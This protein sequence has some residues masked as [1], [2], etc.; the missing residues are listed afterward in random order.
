MADFSG[1]DRLWMGLLRA[2]LSWWARP[3]VLP[4][5]LQQRFAGHERPICYVLNVLGAADL[6]VL[7]RVCAA[8]GLP[9][10]LQALRRPLPQQSV[11]FLERRVGFWSDRIDH[12]ISAPMRQLVA[13]AAADRTLEV[14]LVPVTVMWGRAPDREGSWLRMLLTENWERVGRF[15]RLL[16]VL[17]NGRN[18]F[19]QFGEPVSLRAAL[20]DGADAARAVRR[21]TRTL[22]VALARQ[23][24][25]AIG[26]DLS[27]RRTIATQVL[28]TAAV[29]KAMA[30]E[31][32]ANKISR[33]AALQVAENYAAEIAANYSHIFV[34]IIAR[35]LT[36]FW[37]RLYDGVQLHHFEQLQK[38]ADGNEVVYVPCHRS[39]IDY[40]L[41]S[42]AIYYKGYA[43]PHIAAGINLNMPIAGRFLR[44]GG[45]FFMRRSFKGNALYTMVFMK[46][47]GLMMARGHSIEYFIE[48][49]RSRTGRLLQPK[50]G[51]LSMTL[52]SYLRDPRRPIVFV[53]VYFG[54]ERLVEGK[55]YI[56][57]LSG[58]PKEK[59]SV[60]AMLRALPA[61]RERFG[62][63]HVSFGEP[64]RLE[65]VLAQHA[66]QRA[67]GQ[68]EEEER[69][70]WLAP[71]VNDLAVRIMTSINS[72]ACV[73]PINL[74]ALTLLATPKQSM[75]EGDLVRQLELY[76][77]LMR[78]SSYSP[79]VWITDTDG[80][81]I[82]RH[83]ERMGVI[84]RL[85]HPL[86][87]V[88]Q[89]TEENS[90]LMTYFR[91]NVLHLMALP[92]LIACCFLN[93]RTMRT[94]D[95]QRLMWRIY[96]YVRDELFLRWTEDEI[97]AAVVDILDDLANH[98]LLEA[99][100]AGAQWRRPPTGSTEAVQLSLLAQVTVQI[101]ERYY[102]VIAVL[103][104]SG[105]GRISQ[106]VLE[107][108]CQ[109]MAQR[110]SLLYELNS[111]DFFDKTLFKN[112]IDLLR[113]RNVLGVSADGRLTYTDMLPAVADDAQLVLHEQIRNSVLQVTHR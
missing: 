52:R 38:V 24:A 41:L 91:N 5:D 94:E 45:A 95:I 84:Q 99:V 76:A 85:S 66:P 22:R 34:A 29:R 59:E 18:L 96:P 83:G 17:A 82:V 78:Q 32:R 63:V 54:Y 44:K 72:A 104:K 27:H 6:V 110:M 106:D 109:L 48:G 16:A 26:P 97:G 71:A 108:Q 51:M 43:V 86:G 74:I 103:L 56:G 69:P 92:S 58:K 8:H 20:D 67:R 90:V 102:L 77:S 10:P 113:A 50:T 60:F 101:I 98:G 12:R 15:R 55:T 7:E 14:D 33:R 70:P 100:E 57:E 25:A 89:M 53:P 79:L 30:D 31:M 80:A 49:G 93:N 28:R 37:T 73:A 9:A 13:A 61:M 81:S 87:D 40:L 62:K 88:M 11:L 75:L 112:F 19:V 68:P 46:Y 107:S 36:W 2:P 4:E 42:Y 21:I 23:R 47:L 64:I 1:L 39:H 111:P 35:V 105:S 65:D 3:H